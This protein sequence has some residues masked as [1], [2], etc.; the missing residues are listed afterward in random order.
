MKLK[1]VFSSEDTI[2]F[3]IG[4]TFNGN[5]YIWT[6][7]ERW[8]Y[9]DWAPG[10]PDTNGDSVDTVWNFASGQYWRWEWNDVLGTM[11]KYFICETTY[12]EA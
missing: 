7:G 8:T 10:T 2:T 6:S 3:W 12:T 5:T 9:S 1:V 11:N 4:G